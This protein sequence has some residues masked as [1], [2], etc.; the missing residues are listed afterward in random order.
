MSASDN[1]NKN[2]PKIH[3]KQQQYLPLENSFQIRVGR[4][5]CHSMISIVQSIY[6]F[7]FSLAVF[8]WLS[9]SHQPS[10]SFSLSLFLSQ[11]LSISLLSADHFQSVVADIARFVVHVRSANTLNMHFINAC[12]TPWMAQ[13]PNTNNSLWCLSNL[14]SC[15]VVGAGCCVAVGLITCEPMFDMQLNARSATK[16]HPKN[17]QPMSGFSHLFLKN[18]TTERKKDKWITII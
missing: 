17:I 1:N 9:S 3:G 16:K 5:Q 14:V 4:L 15:I 7:S 8:V 12:C 6:I 11:S 13:T 10:S 18:T 2:V